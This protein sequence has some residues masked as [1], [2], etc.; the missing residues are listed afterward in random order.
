MKTFELK[1]VAACSIAVI[2]FD[3]FINGLAETILTLDDGRI[4][5]KMG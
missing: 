5:L 1:V 4:V 2:T 3:P